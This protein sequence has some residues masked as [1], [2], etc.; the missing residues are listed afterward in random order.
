MMDFI[1]KEVK[2][3]YSEDQGKD[4]EGEVQDLVNKYGEKVKQLLD[5]KEK[6]IMTI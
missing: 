5:A 3:G 6:D 2:D 1:K 4:R